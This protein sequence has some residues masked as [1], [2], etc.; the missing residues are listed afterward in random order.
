MKEVWK[1]YNEHYSISNLGNVRNNHNG[2]L[3]HPH[4]DKSTGYYYVTLSYGK[5]KVL[6]IHRLVAELFIPNDGNLREVDHID[7]DKSHN[8][9]GNLRWV[10][11]SQNKLYAIES[12]IWENNKKHWFSDRKPI[13]AKDINTGEEMEFISINQAERYFNSKHITDVLKNKRSQTKGHTFRYK[14]GD[15]YANHR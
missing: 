6:S 9:V 1:E 11:S 2:K 14:G 12:G 3:L 8:S 7:C 15:A 4:M 13:I 10:T 5:T